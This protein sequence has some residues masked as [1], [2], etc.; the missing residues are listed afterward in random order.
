MNNSIYLRRRSKLSVNKGTKSTHL[1]YVASIM[2]NIEGLGYTLSKKLVVRLQT[3]DIEKIGKIERLVVKT[4]REMTGANK[5]YRPMYPNFPVQV[6]EA[7]EAELYVNAI[8]HYFG[9]WIGVRIMPKYQK[10]KRDE[11]K[12]RVGKLKLIDLGSEKDFGNIFTSL[13]S[14]NASISETDKEDL[15]WFAANYRKDIKD[16]MPNRIP[17]KETMAYV[18]SLIMPF[19]DAAEILSPLFKTATDVLRFAV[20]LSDGD[21]SL[22]TNTKFRNFSRSERR[23][24]LGLLN[25][26][27]SITEDMIRYKKRWIRLGEKIHPGEFKDT[28]KKCYK[29]FDVIRNNKP[30]KTFGNTVEQGLLEKHYSKPG[31]LVALVG[32]LKQRPGELARRL[33]KLLRDAT[34]QKTILDAFAECADKISTPVLLQVMKHFACRNDEKDVSDIRVFFP[35]GNVAKVKAIDNTLPP[36]KNESCLI[37]VK[38]C[39]KA[40]VNRFKKLDPIK[41]VYVDKAL[42]SYLVP[43]SQRSASKALKTLVRGSKIPLPTGG[44]NT[45][46]FFLW[47]KDIGTGYDG[48]VD[49]DLSAIIFDENWNYVDHISYTNLR[50]AC[51]NA[52]HSG[53]ITSAPKGACEFIDMDL[54]AVEDCH[55]ARYVMMTLTSYTTQPYCNLPECFAGW[56]MRSHSKSGE[57]FDARTV[58]NKVDLAADTTI[59]IPVIFDMKERNFIWADIAL[60][61]DPNYSNNIQGNMSSMA[62]MG[63]AMVELKK[64]NLYDLFRLHAKA[65]G[66]LVK[67]KKEA[68]T[69]FSVNGDITPFDTEKIM[70]EFM[71]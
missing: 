67:D 41:N 28:H 31:A 46:R 62:I 11:I 69:V 44:K 15:M 52:C 25:N 12:D 34:G 29:A 39:E 57:I 63:K 54:S 61:K 70:S 48:R 45:V 49:I 36:I 66:K 14:A 4:L 55:I 20:A 59:C 40:L 10:E 17:Q 2:K 19:K 23:F 47:W 30:F 43:F 3:L 37:V 7:S 8:L 51:F 60:K 22:A 65:R 42:D 21:V 1:K 38:E 33:D 50:S 5:N 24:L 71:Q 53:D 6:M 35:K 56:M 27:G 13:V 9:D 64:P 58:A 16:L 18:A 26:A 68:D 32:V